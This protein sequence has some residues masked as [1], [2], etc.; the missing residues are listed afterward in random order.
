[1][2]FMSPSG[3]LQIHAS[4]PAFSYRSPQASAAPLLASSFS[5]NRVIASMP[6]STGKAANRAG[7]AEC[8]HGAVPE[9]T[10][11]QGGLDALADVQAH[12]DVL[13]GVEL[14]RATFGAA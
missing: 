14:D 3:G 4:H 13:V 6:A 5:V 10:S 8:P 9:L 12:G 1:M 2:S 7:R 11:S